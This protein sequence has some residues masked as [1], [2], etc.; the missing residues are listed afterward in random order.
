M[1]DQAALLDLVGRFAVSRVAQER[2]VSANFH[3]ARNAHYS[4]DAVSRSPPIDTFL[5]AND[6]EHRTEQQS[7]LMNED[8]LHVTPRARPMTGV[9]LLRQRWGL[10]ERD[11][12]TQSANETSASTA[13]SAH[14]PAYDATSGFRSSIG[15]VRA[16][17]DSIRARPS[18]RQV[19]D[20]VAEPQSWDCLPVSQVPI[21]TPS[22]GAT[23]AANISVRDGVDGTYLETLKALCV[24]DV[25]ESILE[26]EHAFDVTGIRMHESDLKLHAMS[27]I[28]YRMR[29]AAFWKRRTHWGNSGANDAIVPR[30]S[31]PTPPSILH[32]DDYKSVKP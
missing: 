10:P 23:S 13:P 16:A 8:E 29:C 31:F 27:V 7:F 18:I 32:Q 1:E 24:D 2:T 5:D 12:V 6:D 15:A 21:P 17:I 30:R 11:I 28:R 19:L 20:G 22:H 25:F 14:Q 3:H 9:E 26:Q 4:P